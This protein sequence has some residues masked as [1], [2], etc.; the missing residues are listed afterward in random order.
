MVHGVQMVGLFVTDLES[1][2]EF[3]R[4][5]LGIPLEVDAHG[6]R[7]HADYSFRD[8]YFHFALFPEAAGRAIGPTHVT[9][10]VEDCREAV[11]RATGAGAQVIHEPRLMPYSG[12]GLAAE[13]LDPDG[14]HIELFEPQAD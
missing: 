12:G 11:R 2:V 13:V 5:V 7:R 4:N 14:N 8:P 6:E 1:A 9:F 10:R 3:Y